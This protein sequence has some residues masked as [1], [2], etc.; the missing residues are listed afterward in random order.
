MNARSDLPYRSNVGIAL[1]NHAGLVFA[2]QCIG[3]GPEVIMPG[4]EWQMPQGGLDIGEKTVAASRRELYEETG[5]TRTSL[6]AVSDD[7]WEYD[8]PPYAGPPHKL[9]GFRG[10]KQRWVALRFEGEDSD[11]DVHNPK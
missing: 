5:I 6:L 8:F 11:I 1:F 2:G 10:Q 4:Y 3:S 7:Q 9:C